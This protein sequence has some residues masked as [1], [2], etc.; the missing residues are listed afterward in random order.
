MVCLQNVNP[1]PSPV[2]PRLVNP[3]VDDLE[4][5]FRA[6]RPG[7]RPGASRPPRSRGRIR[8]TRT[9]RRKSREVLPEWSNIHNVRVLTHF[10]QRRADHWNPGREIL[11]KLQRVDRARPIVLDI[12]DDA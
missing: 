6:T 11:E 8:S 5:P 10:R 2:T 12:R 1:L 4:K 9:L 7:V 3:L